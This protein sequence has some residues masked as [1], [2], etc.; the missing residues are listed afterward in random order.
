MAGSTFVRPKTWTGL[1][2]PRYQKLEM[3][4]EMGRDP[5][6][7]TKFPITHTVADIRRDCEGLYISEGSIQ[8]SLDGSDPFILW[9][10]DV[11]LSGRLMAR[12]KMGKMIF[13]EIEDE[14]GRI[15]VLLRG[16]AD[17]LGEEEFLLFKQVTDVGDHLGVKGRMIKSKTGEL[18]IVAQEVTYL[19]KALRPPP[20]KHKG[21]T[22]PEILQRQRYI[23]LAYNDGARQRFADRGAVSRYMREFLWNEGFQEVETPVLQDLHGGASARPFVTH[24]NTLDMDLYLRIAT[25]LHLKRLIAGGFEAVFEIGRIFRNEGIDRSHNPE[26][27]TMECYW[28]RKDYEDMMSLTERMVANI[29]ERIHHKYCI[30]YQGVE[31]DFS[32]PWKRMTMV[33]AIKELGGVDV[34]GM[35]EESLKAVAKERGVEFEDFMGKGWMIATLFDELVEDKLVQPTFIYRYPRETTPLAKRVP[36]DPEW[37]ERFEGYAAGMEIANAFSELNDPLDQRARFEEQVV[38]AAA[39]DEEAQ[40]FDEDYVQALEIGM[41]P[42]GGLGIGIDRLAMLV[43]DSPSIRDVILFPTRKIK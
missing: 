28:A 12:R 17:E 8:D 20:D 13:G 7:I 32:P 10:K 9:P 5:Y 39:G 38:A 36:G 6:A 37:V 18:T 27:T 11:V 3:L 30:P 1:M 43:T 35:T 14:S 41:L 2:M 34:S 40:P 16:N 33:D 42:T 23:D 19:A 24:H 25:E 31:L 21:V 15:Q 22:D 26:F 4:K 29:V